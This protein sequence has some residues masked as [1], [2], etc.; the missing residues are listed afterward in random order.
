MLLECDNLDPNLCSL[1]FHSYTLRRARHKLHLASRVRHLGVVLPQLRVAKYEVSQLL[2]HHLRVLVILDQHLD[3]KHAR[4]P[5]LRR[6]HVRVINPEDRIRHHLPELLVR[7]RAPDDAVNSP[8][9]LLQALELNRVINHPRLPPSRVSVL[10]S[11]D[12]HVMQLLR[13]ERQTIRAAMQ[14]VG[15]ERLGQSEHL[16]TVGFCLER[17][18]A[19]IFPLHETVRQQV[20]KVRHRFLARVVLL[21]D[22]GPCGR[23]FPHREG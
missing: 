15:A 8:I 12:Q 16:S 10:A 7:P 9:V 18:D 6:M 1:P 22:L 20:R 4:L 3:V 2:L 13:S 19:L 14:I 21:R 23:E 17:A 11:V 5:K